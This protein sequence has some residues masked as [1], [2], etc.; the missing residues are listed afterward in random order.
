MNPSS[1]RRSR[2]TGLLSS[3]FRANYSIYPPAILAY[4]P[5]MLAGIPPPRPS[6]AE[7]R[8]SG[9][10]AKRRRCEALPKARDVGMARPKARQPASASPEGAFEC[11]VRKRASASRKRVSRLKARSPSPKA[12]PERPRPQPRP[13][14]ARPAAITRSRARAPK[15]RNPDR[16]TERPRAPSAQFWPRTL[17]DT[18]A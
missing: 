17:A 3:I 6:R 11:P 13:R 14:T 5:A 2:S 8:G 15:A 12:A 9:A 1:I 16:Y 4:M 18:S 10:V 7:R